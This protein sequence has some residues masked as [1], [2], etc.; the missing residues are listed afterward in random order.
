MET[1]NKPMEM[2]AL[3]TKTVSQVNKGR[4]TNH[5]AQRG[6]GKKGGLN[7][8]VCSHC[9]KTGH[10]VD[11]CWVLHPHLRPATTSRSPAAYAVAESTI[12]EAPESKD[13]SSGIIVPIDMQQQL[14]KAYGGIHLGP[15]QSIVFSGSRL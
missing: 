15:K 9:S 5:T 11:Q 7:R 13:Q 8:P 2:S 6:R 10:T 12:Q 4:F 3:A 1:S 14:L